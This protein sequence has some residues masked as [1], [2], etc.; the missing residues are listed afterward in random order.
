MQVSL[1]P[2]LHE[3]AGDG[4]LRPAGGFR[5]Y[6]S[7]SGPGRIDHLTNNVEDPA[8]DSVLRTG[9]VRHPVQAVSHLLRGEIVYAE[10]R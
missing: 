8:H 4:S 5:A 9:S 6:R 2:F 1:C 10:W 7:Q 3:A